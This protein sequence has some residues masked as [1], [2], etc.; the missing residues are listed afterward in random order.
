MIGRPGRKLESP[1]CDRLA[2]VRSA[3]TRRHPAMRSFLT[4]R[5]DPRI[6]GAGAR[7]IPSMQAL[8]EPKRRGRDSNPRWTNQAH[9]GFRDRRM[10]VSMTIALTALH[11]SATR[12]STTS[13]TAVAGDRRDLEVRERGEEGRAQ[14][15]LVATQGR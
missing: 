7:G 5:E 3:R 11:P 1:A 10:I 12:R 13:W 6:E 2:I 8:Y 14:R 15:L 9:N 4:S